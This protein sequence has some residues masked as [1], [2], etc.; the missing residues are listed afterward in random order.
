MFGHVTSPSI[1]GG[2]SLVADLTRVRVDAL[3]ALQMGIHPANFDVFT[4]DGTR[5][6]ACPRGGDCVLDLVVASMPALEWETYRI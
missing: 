6:G 4:T 5:I 2:K 1:C 3:V